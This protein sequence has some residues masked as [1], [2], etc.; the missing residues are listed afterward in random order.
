[1]YASAVIIISR[2]D[3]MKRIEITFDKDSVNYFDENMKSTNPLDYPKYTEKIE[4]LI[5]E[6]KINEAVNYWHW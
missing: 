4:K 5:N 2:I 1:M 6:L 3:S